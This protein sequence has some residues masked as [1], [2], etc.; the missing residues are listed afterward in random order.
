MKAPTDST[1]R[2]CIAGQWQNGKPRGKIGPKYDTWYKE[3][4]PQLRNYAD[5]SKTLHIE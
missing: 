1:S 4:Q 5:N 2:P 3:T